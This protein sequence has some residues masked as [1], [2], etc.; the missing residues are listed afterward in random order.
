MKTTIKTPRTT[1]TK[2]ARIG[3]LVTMV[4]AAG[5]TKTGQ[6]VRSEL[7]HIWIEFPGVYYPV[8]GRD[9]VYQ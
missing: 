2:N 4:D 3:Q 6:V 9:V 7:N 5:Q 1:T 8:N